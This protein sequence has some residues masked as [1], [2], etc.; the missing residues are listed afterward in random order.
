[1]P[2]PKVL[3]VAEYIDYFEYNKILGLKEKGYKQFIL[4]NP[5]DV[6]FNKLKEAGF[7]NKELILNSKF[8]K[9]GTEII[10]KAIKEF[11][12][13]IIHCLPESKTVANSIRALKNFPKNKI[14]LV[15]YRGVVGNISKLY[16]WSYLTYLNPRIDKIIC[17]SKN[18]F[19]Y[20]LKVGLAKEKLVVIHKGVDF[21]WHKDILNSDKEYLKKD[22]IEKNVFLIST[23]GSFRTVKGLKYLLEAIDD[24]NNPLIYLMVIGKIKS[25]YEKK[26]LKDLQ[27]RKLAKF[28]NYTDNPLPLI[29]DSDLYIV[30]SVQETF[31]RGAL[32]S[33]CVNTPVISTKV[34]GMPE[35]LTDRFAF[36]KSKSKIEIKNAIEL[37]FN[38]FT[39]DPTKRRSIINQQ[40]DFLI[41]NF[42]IEKNIYKTDEFYKLMALS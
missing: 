20:F 14:K 32:E 30:P 2:L 8:D 24:L 18:V 41:K 40:R 35:M 34:G 12:P 22:N 37:Y 21:N 29:K 16:P 31:S 17:N 33:I 15:A 23:M 9:V 25:E 19:N 42:N 11:S 13:G 4:C 5:K 28:V 39:S 26:L 10:H 36:I 6:H 1:M 3:I 38:L 7:K 27:E